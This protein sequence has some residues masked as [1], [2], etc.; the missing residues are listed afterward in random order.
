MPLSKLAAGKI[1]IPWHS[2]VLS[3]LRLIEVP[4][5]TLQ[6][7]GAGEED[8]LKKAHFIPRVNQV[9]ALLNNGRRR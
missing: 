8:E 1:K 7:D 5:G 4:Y 9:S 6:P 3:W 2:T